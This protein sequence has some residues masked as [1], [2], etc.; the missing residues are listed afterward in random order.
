[1]TAAN[2]SKDYQLGYRHGCDSDMPNTRGVFDREA[3]FT[4]YAAGSQERDEWLVRGEAHVPIPEWMTPAQVEAINKLYWRSADGA[5]NRRDFFTRVAQC[6][7]GSD[8]YAGLHWG[9]MFVGIEPD[10]YTHT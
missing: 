10:G 1:V 6:G 3:Y 4:G 5:R 7:F 8:Q 2:E 9:D